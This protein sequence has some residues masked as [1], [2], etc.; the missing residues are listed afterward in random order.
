M[1]HDNY[2][3]SRD[4]END[5]DGEQAESRPTSKSHWRVPPP[6]LPTSA[7]CPSFSEE[8]ARTP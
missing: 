4:D 3:G 5:D 7:V 8:G 6:V 1:Q 2:G